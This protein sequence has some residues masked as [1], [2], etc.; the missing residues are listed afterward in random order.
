[1]ALHKS[2][3]IAKMAKHM[4][5]IVICFSCVF[6]FVSVG[7][8]G[9]PLVCREV[10]C[11]CGCVLSVGVSFVW[12]SYLQANLLLNLWSIFPFVPHKNTKREFNMLPSQAL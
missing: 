6:V 11:I 3:S 10:C 8:W 12:E 9:R 7:R 5:M 4:F 2:E 1:M